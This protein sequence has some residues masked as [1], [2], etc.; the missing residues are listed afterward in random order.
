[1]KCFDRERITFINR[2]GLATYRCGEFEK[3][4]VPGTGQPEGA[5]MYGHPGSDYGS[6]CSPVCGYNNASVTLPLARVPHG[7]YPMRTGPDIHPDAPNRPVP[8]WRA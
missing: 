2:Y 6:S 1:M 3:I 5:L 8:F 7:L 4:V